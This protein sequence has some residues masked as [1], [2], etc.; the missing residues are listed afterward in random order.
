M[1]RAITAALVAGLGL[2]APAVSQEAGK[3]QGK[4]VVNHDRVRVLEAYYRPGD[5]APSIE[6]PFRVVRALKGG[7]LELIHPDGTRESLV[8][9]DGE[10]KLLGPDPAFS[11][12]NAGNTDVHLYA[13][14]VK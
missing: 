5:V 11:V 13:V 9:A 2:T 6:R 8:F 12:R 7:T 10:T 4:L 3:A 14:E 1:R